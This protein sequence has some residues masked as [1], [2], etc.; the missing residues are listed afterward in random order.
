MNNDIIYDY[1]TNDCH[2]D[3]TY[4]GSNWSYWSGRYRR[5]WRCD[6]MYFLD[7]MVDQENLPEKK[8]MGMGLNQ[9]W[10]GSYSSR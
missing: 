3:S 2:T 8:I 6:C 9:K 10:L 1:V 7:D 4:G 5:I